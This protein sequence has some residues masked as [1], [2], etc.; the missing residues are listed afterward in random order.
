MVASFLVFLF[1]FLQLQVIP[2]DYYDTR[3]G[4]SNNIIYDI[5][6]DKNGFIWIATE[7]GL[8]RFDGYEFTVFHHVPGDSTSIPSNVV[9]TIT[10]DDEG[11]VWIGTFEGLSL[12]D[13]ES[14]TFRNYKK[15]EV[16]NNTSMDIQILY[17]DSGGDFWF[18]GDGGLNHFDV[19]EKKFDIVR[20]EEDIHS[21]VL[22]NKDRIWF[23]T[24]K[25][26]LFIYDIRRKETSKLPASLESESLAL[27][28]G[29]EGK[30]VFGFTDQV[31]DP[32][33]RT[34]SPVPRPL[35]SVRLLEDHSGRI[36][37][38]SELGL[39]LYDIESEEYSEIELQGVTNSLLQSVRSLSEDKNGG[40]WIG[41]LNGIFHIDPNYNPFFTAPRQEM[42]MGLEGESE[43]LWV[44]YFSLGITKYDLNGDEVS[45]PETDWDYYPDSDMIWDIE[46]ENSS[47]MLLGTSAGLLRWSTDTGDLSRIALPA[48]EFIE[49]VIFSVKRWEDDLWVL[50]KNSIYQLKGENTEVEKV[51]YLDDHFAD[52]LLQDMAI[53]E[54]DTLIA[55]EGNGIFEYNNGNPVKWRRMM[56]QHS[57]LKNTSIWDLYVSTTG[58]LWIGGNNGLFSYMN[59]IG[60]KHFELAEGNSE[61]VFSI[62]E[63]ENGV[64]WLG[65]DRGVIRLNPDTDDFQIFD[66]IDGAGSQEFNRRSITKIGKRIYLGG[67]NG[68]TFFNPDDIYRNEVPPDVWITEVTVIKADSSLPYQILEKNQIE[69]S[70]DENTIEIDFVALNYSNTAENKY[71]YKLEGYDPDWVEDNTERKARYVRLPA[72]EYTFTVVAS[73]NDGVWNEVG[74][75]LKVIVHPPYWQTVWFKLLIIILVGG[76][77]Y[78]LYRYRVRQLLEV[79]RVRL[80]I[81]GDLHDEIGSGLSGIALTGD[82]LKNH[83]DSGKVRPEL[84]DRITRNARNLASSL[85]AIVWLIDPGKERLGDLVDKCRSISEEMLTG[86]LV[87]FYDE[88]TEDS[89]EG[90]LNSTVRRNVYLIFK[91]AIHNVYKHSE[92]SQVEIRF[93]CRSGFLEL[94]VKD[95]G[96]GF[97]R[98]KIQKG[99]GLDSFERRA[100]DMNAELRLRTDPGKGT[101]IHLK[102][103]LP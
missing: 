55:A 44:N 5:Y 54:D 24:F 37:V 66:T 21:I 19:T 78:M 34:L 16:S 90:M 47:F 43:G 75:S 11:R 97:N 32:I 86:Y 56:D 46:R 67:M 77:I 91:E 103:K 80:R 8:N 20:I 36:W 88:L 74:D 33:W 7:N 57:E 69:L 50:G 22:D 68:V 79:E 100:A 65:T 82:I 93:I 98:V 85:D 42:V 13:R 53:Y 10:E 25:N 29:M 102:V 38:S 99:N 40:I 71:K 31:T 48:R 58:V 83:V 101:E 30:K 60:F 63:D 39:W 6:Q 12:Y 92:A 84:V 64:L 14:D 70:W 72:N 96:V 35:R 76:I 45:L 41:T 89:R 49:P 18:I 2:A 94:T 59:D 61:I 87:H 23:S 62:T 51:I 27:F 15:S 17:K 95:D 1:A 28:S 3:K 52:P 4:L 81:A 73:N 9:R 26:E